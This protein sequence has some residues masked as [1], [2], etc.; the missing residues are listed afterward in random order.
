MDDTDV[1][2]Q[3]RAELATVLGL[4]PSEIDPEANLFDLGL[5]SLSVIRLLSSLESRYGFTLDLSTI[6]ASPTVAG[7]GSA[8]ARGR[9]KGGASGE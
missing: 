8:V 5:N 3:I 9:Q 6:F 2:S 4:D 7:L 1:L